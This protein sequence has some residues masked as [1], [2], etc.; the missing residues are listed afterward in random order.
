MRWRKSLLVIC[1]IVRLF[2]NTLTAD[3]KHHLR[4]RDNLRQQIEMQLYQN[5]KNFSE[6]FFAFLKSLL[7]FKHFE[8]KKT[9]KADVFPKL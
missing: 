9:L 3:D 6:F 4:N 8:K 2:V 7:K 5:Q 1:K